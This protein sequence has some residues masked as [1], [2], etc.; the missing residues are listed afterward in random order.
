[1][2]SRGTRHALPRGVHRGTENEA[3]PGCRDSCDQES[4]RRSGLDRC[5]EGVTAAKE[6]V[7]Q[8]RTA[9][10]R[11]NSPQVNVPDAAGGDDPAIGRKVQRQNTYSLW[12]SLPVSR[13]HSQT[14]PRVH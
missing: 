8:H 10:L 4:L 7:L 12:I 6:E 3:Q 14:A 1:M 5:S 2:P 11:L 9:C 13:F